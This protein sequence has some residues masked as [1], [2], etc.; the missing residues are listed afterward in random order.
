MASD[1]SDVVAVGVG[2]VGAYEIDTSGGEAGTGRG[3]GVGV[4]ATC[5][6]GEIGNWVIGTSRGSGACAAMSI[7]TRRAVGS[8]ACMTRGAKPGNTTAAAATRQTATKRVPILFPLA[9]LSVARGL[10]RSG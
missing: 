6:G 4:A 5:G 8:A 1:L 9:S 10:I 7:R 3:R 2:A